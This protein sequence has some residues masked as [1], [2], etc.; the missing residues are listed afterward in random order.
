MER[1]NQHQSDRKQAKRPPRRPY[2]RPQISNSALFE[3]LALACADT[4]PL[5]VGAPPS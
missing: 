5:C 3:S 2:R 1:S 4:G